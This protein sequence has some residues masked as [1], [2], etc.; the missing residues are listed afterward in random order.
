MK[1]A[2]VNYRYFVSGGPERYMF[3]IK[4]VLEKHGHIVAPFSIK[5]NKNIK[6]DYEP[7]FLDAIGTGNEVY[8]HEYPADL[9]TK[10]QVVGRMLY[11]FEAKRKFKHFL[12]EV[13]PDIVYILH[14]QNK[15]SCSIID[16]AKEMNIPVVQRISD[17]G[18]ICPNA[19][20]YREKVGICESCTSKSLFQAVK[21]KCISNSYS[22]SA[23][24][25]FSLAIMNINRVKDKVDGFV[26]PSS[27]TRNKYIAKG[28]DVKKTFHIPTFFNA[29]QLAQSKEIRYGNFAVYVGRL[30]KEKGIETL[31]NAFLKTNHKLKIIGFSN[32]SYETSLKNMAQGREDQI[33]FIGK[34]DFEEI[35]HYLQE[36]LFTV[37]PSEWFE[38]FPNTVL[39]SFAFKKAVLATNI[40]SLPEI[41]NES[42]GFCFDYA[43]SDSLR[44]KINYMFSNKEEAQIKGEN[45]FKDLSAS[46]SADYHY[47]QLISVFK[48]I[49]NN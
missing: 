31:I 36:C 8:N 41:V 9:K 1:I 7:Y 35:S 13:Q 16:A 49:K 47:S 2:L 26:F 25:A 14:F 32:D 18:H 38:N 29:E 4:E 48:R 17:F 28:F 30:E 40:G 44:E 23:L 22:H 19:H 34:L 3:N 15:L 11:S 33:E 43:S 37:V 20:L 46:Y 5:H 24:K 10:I 21:H 42:N 45:G 39:E 12:K 27:F 6:S